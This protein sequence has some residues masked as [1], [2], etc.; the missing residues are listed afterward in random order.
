MVDRDERRRAESLERQGRVEDAARA[1]LAAGSLSNAVR[2]FAESGR[3]RDAGNLIMKAIRCEPDEVGPLRGEKRRLAHRAALHYAAAHDWEP[4]ITI[5]DELGDQEAATKLRRRR[6]GQDRT[7]VSEPPPRLSDPGP[8]PPSE[9]KSRRHSSETH[10]KRRRTSIPSLDR[11]GAH[12]L[13]VRLEARGEMHLAKT[14]YARLGAHEDVARIAERQGSSVEAAEA[15]IKAGRHDEA[16]RCYVDAGD[17][18]AA[19]DQLL[20]TPVDHRSYREAAAQAIELARGLSRMD[21]EL[22]S[23]VMPLVESGVRANEE[24]AVFYELGRLYES[25]GHS[26]RAR[27]VYQAVAVYQP[28]YRDATARAQGAV[29]RAERTGD[30]MMNGGVRS[31]GRDE[32]SGRWESHERLPEI[33]SSTQ[34]LRSRPVPRSSAPPEPE[35]GMPTG[36]MIGGRYRVKRKVGEG[37]MAEVYEVLDLDLEAIIALKLFHETND[38][39]LLLDRCRRELMLARELTHENIVRVYDIGLHERRRFI[40][41]EMLEGTDLRDVMDEVPLT[42]GQSI[43]YL[44]QMCAGLHAAHLKGV[45]H[46]DVK[47]ENF[48]VTKT[49]QVKVMDFGIAKKATDTDE[50]PVEGKTAGTPVYMSPEQ[51]KDYGSVTPVSDVYSMGVVAFEMLTGEVP[52]DSDDAYRLLMMHVNEPAPP[53]SLLEPELPPALD[54]LVGHALAKRP[55]DR[56]RSCREMADRLSAILTTMG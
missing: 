22:D 1:Y 40:T 19:L 3:H 39:R 37:G 29:A 48:F 24:V 56:L 51:I 26:A 4:A 42:W 31:S 52:F 45:V 47:P 50:I 36:S 27:E 2:V 12:G 8:A 49:D 25:T 32:V 5:L 35:D 21:L 23:F 30:R 46:R 53:P 15:W 9:P 44:I 54:E 16:A 13:A 38:A 14:A 18:E 7:P 28:H 34:E 10:V 41:M 6:S 43:R 33:H 20:Y 11:K 55:E 17:E